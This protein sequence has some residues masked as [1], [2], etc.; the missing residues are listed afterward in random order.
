[1]MLDKNKT[2]SDRDFRILVTAHQAYP[3]FERLC[4]SAR[5]EIVMGFRIFDPFT[6]LRSTDA[7]EF[8]QTWLDLIEHL[9]KRGVRIELTI[10]DFDP[11]A[12]PDAH[13]ETWTSIRAIH[14]AGESSGRPD[15]LNARAAMHPARL[16][17]LPRLLL[18]PRALIEL[19]KTA[20]RLNDLAPSERETYL[21]EAP[22]LSR[23]LRDRNGHLATRIWPMPELI[24]ATHHHKLAVIDGEV[25]YIGGLDLNERRYDSPEH[26][27]DAEETWHDV[28]LTVRGPVAG[29]AR[30]HLQ[31]FETVAGGAKTPHLPNLLRTVSRRCRLPLLRMSPKPYLTEIADAHADCTVRARRLIY[32]ETQYFRD[33]AYARQLARQARENPD[34]RLLLILPAAPE[35]VAFDANPSI[36]AKYGEYLQAKCVK[37]VTEAF[38]DRV[39]IGSPAQRRRAPTGGRTT[40]YGAP[41]IY[42]H[43]KVSIFDDNLALVSSANLNGRSF[44]WDTEAGLALSDADHIRDLWRICARQWLGWQVPEDWLSPENAVP[45]WREIAQANIHVPPPERTGFLLPYASRPARRY[46][47][48]LPGIPEA[49]V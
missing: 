34:L 23:M 24:P 27:R 3:E 13:R 2:D 35:E 15:L 18:W 7:L 16:G 33:T 29:E 4:L 42:V 25:L 26:D 47:H 5:S 37:L 20:R 6:R 43:S 21:H 10:A 12:R 1:M 36:D 45:V 28:Q 17:Y 48:T 46:G 22:R 38:G 11:V 19:Q 44:R 32:L 30:Q 9:L 49:M 31:C 14:K 8:G 41:I 40:L 39:F